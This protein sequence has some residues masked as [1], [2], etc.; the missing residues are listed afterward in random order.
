MAEIIKFKPKINQEFL[1]GL[2]ELE[3]MYQQGLINKIVIIAQ[4]VEGKVSAANGLTVAEV[5]EIL[6]DWQQNTKEYL[7]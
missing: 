5:R 4:G 7:E 1:D 6:K 3:Q 2:R